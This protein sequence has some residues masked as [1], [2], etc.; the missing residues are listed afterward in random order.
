MVVPM[1]GMRNDAFRAVLDAVLVREITFAIEQVQR[2]PAEEAGSPVFEVVAGVEGAVVM[3]EIFVVHDRNPPARII[4][5]RGLPASG[6]NLLTRLPI[7]VLPMTVA[8]IGFSFP[9]R[10]RGSGRFSL[11]FPVSWCFYFH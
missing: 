2:A 7:M 11:L 10:L 9:S 8:L 6:S 3:R 4:V 5:H 1:F